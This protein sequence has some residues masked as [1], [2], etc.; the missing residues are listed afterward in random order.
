MTADGQAVVAFDKATGQ[1]TGT[2]P[3]GKLAMDV[4]AAGH[5]VRAVYLYSGMAE[6]AMETGDKNKARSPAEAGIEIARKR[7][8]GEISTPA[9]A[10]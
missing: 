3:A 1:L 6:V 5:A 10:G 2:P 9:L 8:P 7:V 4:V